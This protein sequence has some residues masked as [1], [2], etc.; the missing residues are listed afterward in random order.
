MKCSKTFFGLLAFVIIAVSIFS[1]RYYISHTFRKNYTDF[2]AFLH[3]EGDTVSFFKVHFK[4]GDV[5]VME[6]WSLNPRKD[7]LL[8][9]GELFDFNRSQKKQ[10]LLAFAIEDI[11]IVETNQIEAIENRDNDRIAGLTL[12]TVINVGMGLFCAFNPKAC[13]GSCPTFYLPGDDFLHSSRAEG[14]SSSISPVLERGDIDALNYSSSSGNVKI[15]MKNEALETHCINQLGVY[16]VPRGKDERVFQDKDSI[17]Y[18]CT[19][20]ASCLRA[21][22]EQEDVKEL[23]FDVDDYEYFSPADSHEL[24]TKEE[25]I[26][27]FPFEGKGAPGLVI[28]FR[29]SLLTTFLLYSGLSYMGDEVGDF[30]AT[31]ERKEAVRKRLANPFKRLGKIRLYYWN[32]GEDCW[33]FFEELYETGPIAKNLQ[34]APLPEVNSYPGKLKVKIEMSKGLWRVDYAGLVTVKR[35]VAPYFATPQSVT[36]VDGSGSVDRVVA[37]DDQYLISFPGNEFRFDFSFP[38]TSGDQDF[39]LFLYSKGY[40]IEWMRE[41]WLAGKNIPKLTK[42]LRND[43]QTWQDLAKEYKTLE[44]EMEETFWNSKFSRL[45]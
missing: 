3:E 5:C 35:Q 30:F 34:V 22:V 42:M 8:G 13:F 14:F 37:D 17:F 36:I 16:A 9:Q 20:P 44:S 26:L 27:E 4:N 12:I 10:G 40:Y 6:K 18:V 45:Q 38:P 2:N 19:P 29:Q 33:V 21:K 1:C 43:P 32:E 11:A 41:E 24:S 28:N 25:I 23:L 15:T 31:L 7:S 39:E